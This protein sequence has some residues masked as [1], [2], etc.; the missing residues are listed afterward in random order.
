MKSKFLGCGGA[1]AASNGMR[2]PQAATGGGEQYAEMPKTLIKKY[3]L[4]GVR[5]MGCVER[6]T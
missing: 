5:L 6:Q 4:G 2:P 1:I 3:K